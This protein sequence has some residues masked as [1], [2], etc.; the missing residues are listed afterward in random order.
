MLS[1]LAC[2]KTFINP[3]LVKSAIQNAPKS[4]KQIFRTFAQE[5]RYQTRAERI[6]QRMSLKER[7][8]APAGPNSFAIGR[9]ALAGGSLIGLG[10]LCF[11]GF[12]LSKGGTNALENSMLWPQYVKQRIQDTYLYFGGSILISGAAAAAVFR[13]PVLLRLVSGSGWLSIIGTMAAMIAS[14]MIVRSISYEPGFGTK[15]L[16]WMTHSAI[17]GAVI[18]P[19]C[20]IG[21]PIMMR[22]AWYT[23][24]WS[25]NI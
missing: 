25:S 18:A 8:M 22:A 1:R 10:A 9:G 3:I 21:G 17:L 19:L 24:G 2:T 23:A 13:T 20:F 4:Q 16:A 12:G 14:G 6:N 11:Y 5:S 7:A 15:Q